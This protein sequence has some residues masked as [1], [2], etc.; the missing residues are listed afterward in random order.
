L[1]HRDEN[2]VLWAVKSNRYRTL[3]DITQDLNEGKSPTKTVHKCTV[4]RF[5]KKGGYIKEKLY[6]NPW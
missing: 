1:S 6:E 3:T 4:Q 2:W 5:L